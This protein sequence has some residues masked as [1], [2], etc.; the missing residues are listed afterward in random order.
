ML[1]R[2][3]CALCTFRKNARYAILIMVSS[4]VPT[5]FKWLERVAQSR[6]QKID[7]AKVWPMEISFTM[8]HH[9]SPNCGPARSGQR[10]SSHRNSP[11]VG[12]FEQFWYHYPHLKATSVCQRRASA[13]RPGGLEI[14]TVAHYRTS[15][16][17]TI[18]LRTHQTHWLIEA[19][20][21]G[22]RLSATQGKPGRQMPCRGIEWSSQHSRSKPDTL[23][24][25]SSNLSTMAWSGRHVVV[26][27][28]KHFLGQSVSGVCEGLHQVGCIANHLQEGTTPLTVNLLRKWFHTALMQL[29]HEEGKLQG[30]MK[31]V[32]D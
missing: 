21:P 16:V 8:M 27:S 7:S 4:F 30:L 17:R 15:R 14:P 10:R 25:R 18:L 9:A 22:E 1:D 5:Y 6:A 13:S 19:C 26:Q 24:L 2:L 28:V 20:N 32:D 3:T 23:G 11:C 31:I 12:M 29:R